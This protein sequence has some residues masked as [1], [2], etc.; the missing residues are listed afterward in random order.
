MRQSSKKCSTDLSKKVS[1]THVSKELSEQIHKKAIPFI[2]WLKEAEVETSDDESDVELE[3]DEKAKISS[4]KEKKVTDRYQYSLVG[5][6]GSNAR[7]QW[8][9]G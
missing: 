6:Y 7:Q 1:K 9:S 2:T 3:F 8:F 5:M 4:I